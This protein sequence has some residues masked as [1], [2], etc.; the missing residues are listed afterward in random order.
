MA[1]PA[2]EPIWFELMTRDSSVTAP[3]YAAVLGWRFVDAGMDDAPAYTI[4]KH[5]EGEHDDV[6]GMMRLAPEMLSGGARPMWAAYFCV[7]DVDDIVRRVASAGG[8]VLMPPTDIE[9]V[10]RMA[11]V[12][13]PH[14]NPFYVMRGFHD[15]DSHV[16]AAGGGYDGRC[17]WNELITPDLEA[18]LGFYRDIFGYDTDERMCMGGD[19]GDYVF[20]KAG[21][22]TI[23]AAMTAM[24]GSSPGWRF[25]FR[26]PD[27]HAARSAIEQNGGSVIFGPE[28]VPDDE[29]IV[30]A[31]DPEGTVFGLLA[32]KKD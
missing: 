16:F 14:G 1:N 6:G 32:P 10:G 23:G 21:D 25:Y 19:M 26:V 27:I 24:E 5:G 17:G 12:A 31:H 11:F 7:N 29:V 30:L 20:L 15:M 8:S 3:F 4:I 18:A 22:R 2:G 9:N 28:D 13:D